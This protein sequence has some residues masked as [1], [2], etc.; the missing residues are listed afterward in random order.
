MKRIT[1]TLILVISAIAGFAQFGKKIVGNNKYTEVFHQVGEYN[2]LV[3]SNVKA[4]IVYL[5]EADSAGIVKIYGEENILPLIEVLSE[6][7]TVTIKAKGLKSNEHGLLMIYVFCAKIR[8]IDLTGGVIFETNDPI[9]Q[10]E[11]KLAVTGGGQILIHKLNSDK[12]KISVLGNGDVYVGGKSKEGS[13]SVVGDGEIRADN[14]VTE[15]LSAKLFG[16]GNIGCN[17]TKLLK[18][19]I[20]GVGNIYYKGNPE[21]KSTIIGT[22]NLKQLP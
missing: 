5:D 15:T 11:M 18:A 17:A 8:T 9:T 22:G 10:P 19:T 21:L 2:K 13:F 12:L 16:N 1:L 4:N 20:T 3:V 6:K 7:Q 14:F